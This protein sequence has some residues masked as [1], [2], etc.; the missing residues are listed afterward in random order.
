MRAISRT[1]LIDIL[2]D[3]KGKGTMAFG[4]DAETDA[5]LLKK[6]R[7]TKE[8]CLFEGVVKRISVSCLIGKNYANAVNRQTLIDNGVKPSGNEKAIADELQRLGLPVFTPKPRKWGTKIDGTAVIEH[9]GAHYVECIFREQDGHRIAF[10]GYFDKDGNKIDDEALEGYL[11]AKSRNNTQSHNEH[12]EYVRDYKAE[13]FK[14]VRMQGE[15][16]AVM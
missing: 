1:K 3:R 9:K 7:D 15:E 13:S 16:L 12:E 4:F 5:R 11:P 14:V 8:P 2:L 6:H 10:L